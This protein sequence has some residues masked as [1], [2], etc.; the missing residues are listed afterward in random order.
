MFQQDSP[1]DIQKRLPFLAGFII[2]FA[3]VLLVRLWYLQAV[4]G[5]YYYELAGRNR[6]RPGKLR[7]PGG[8]I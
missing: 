5:A 2:F 8:S 3:I 1:V 4:K 7:P 6:V